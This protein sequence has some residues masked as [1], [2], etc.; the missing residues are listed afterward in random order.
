MF[1]K[2]NFDTWERKEHFHYYMNFIKTNYNLTAELD[3]TNLLEKTKEKNLKFFPTMLYCITK[4]VNQNKEFRMDY[5]ND[6]NL[7]Y[8]DFVVPSYTIFHEDDK[9]FSDIW[10]EYSNDFKIFYKNVIDDIEKYKDIKGIKTKPGRGNNFCPISSLPWL[11]FT[12]CADDTFTESKMLF[13]VIT[14]GKYFRKDSKTLIP[15]SIFVNH[16]VADGYHTCKLINDIQNIILD[17]EN[18]I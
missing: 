16:A 4:G 9:T 8:W 1:H 2:I 10:S 18:W 15:I 14:F 13:P 5:D 3:I 17:I 7:G 11:S 12:G 6:G